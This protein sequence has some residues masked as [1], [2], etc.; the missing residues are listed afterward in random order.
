MK[1]DLDKYIVDKEFQYSYILRSL[2]LVFFVM[3]STFIIILVWNKFRFYQGYLLSPPDGD[4]VLA[5]A[6]A[7]NVA[8]DGPEFAF[9][10]LAQ[11]KPYSFYNIIIT[12]VLLIFALNL[13]IITLE[14]IYISYKI[15][16]PLHELKAALRR[17]VETGNFAKPLTVREEDPFHELTSLA[18]LA[19]SV[20]VHP[21]VKPY[22]EDQ[23]EAGEKKP[24]GNNS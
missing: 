19:F 17:K 18:N 21:N 16:A 23:P 9:Q 7:N 22:V 4:Q 20:A 8:T 5:W 14:S 6:K 11:A 10:F 2:M 13:I 24:T 12:P 1:L 3:L 15:A